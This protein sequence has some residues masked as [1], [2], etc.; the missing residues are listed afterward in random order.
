MKSQ[1]AI[2]AVLLVLTPQVAF[3]L[4]QGEPSIFMSASPT[5]QDAP[6]GGSAEFTITIYPQESWVKGSV[7]LELSEPPEGVTATFEP[8]PVQAADP[9]L[10]VSV[11]T[12]NISS[13]APQGMVALKIVGR[14]VED[15]KGTKVESDV[16]VKLNIV[17]PTQKPNETKPVEPE[18]V[19]TVTVTV[20]SISFR[21]VS[22]TTVVSS[23]T[24][25][26]TQVLTTRTPTI[27]TSI[28]VEQL[29]QMGELTL[30]AVMFI[31]VVAMLSVAFIALRR[32]S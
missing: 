15:I 16:G 18:Q 1:I 5:A 11:M 4:V 3:A 26:V 9:E 13:D 27:A 21:S 23:V 32:K 22:T 25:T 19:K 24:S 28:T 14:G 8:N 10:G 31:G 17:E 20:T 29:S 12:V 6:A 30:P 2:I 7:N